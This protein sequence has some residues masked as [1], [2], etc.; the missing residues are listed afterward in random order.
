MTAKIILASTSPFRRAL[1]AN[2]GV[3]FAVDR[4]RIDE[5]AVE[6]TTRGSGI[7]PAEVGLILARAKAEEVSTR[8]PESVV[9]GSDQTLAFEDEL[10]HKPKDMEAARRRLIAFSGRTHFLNSAVAIARNGETVWSHVAEATMTMRP[11]DPAF[12][13][14]H[15]ARV[16]EKALT[17]VG[18]Y[19]VEGEGI[20]LFER[21][22]GDHFTIVGLPLLSLLEALRKL[23]AI[24]G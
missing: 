8:H 11:L 1:L 15:L 17:S 9:I 14:R 4:P 19:Q 16:G 2:A 10:L 18:A 6:E 22:E 3:D 21:I 24:D 7:T 23:G 13:G 5:R 20:Q 12:I